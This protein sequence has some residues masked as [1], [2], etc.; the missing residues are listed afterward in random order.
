MARLLVSVRSAHEAA[1]AAEAGA[2]IIDIKEPDLGSLGRAP[3]HVWRE[4]VARLG[5]SLPISVALGELFEWLEPESP[6]LNGLGWHGLRYRKLGLANA[7][8]GWK[9]RWR[10]LRDHP[11]LS[12]GP[13]WIAVAYSD[14]RSAG[15]PS[16]DAVLE[17]AAEDARITGILVDTFHKM[18]HHP[19]GKEWAA[20]SAEAHRAGLMLAI[21]GS[22][23]APAIRRLDDLHPD[24][25]AVRGAACHGGD[26]RSSIDPARVAELA[27]CVAELP[28]AK[29][30]R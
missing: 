24:I 30:T 12:D 2:E 9:P 16:P 23:D 4:V 21:A 10:E 11:D 14:W 18:G 1:V 3:F 8:S 17:A 27:R 6:D 29:F 15:A 28:A 5:S 26:R 25:V 19:L 22:L 13:E 20:W 7:P